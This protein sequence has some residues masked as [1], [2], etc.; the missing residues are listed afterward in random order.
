MF[1]AFE[2]AKGQFL[3][4]LSKGSELAPDAAALAQEAKHRRRRST[5][6]RPE[7]KRK[8]LEAIIRFA[9]EQKI[10]PRAINPEE[11]VRTETP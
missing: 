10:L 1:A 5:P 11:D 4:E 9:H 6:K 3:K 2:A 8:A 7:R